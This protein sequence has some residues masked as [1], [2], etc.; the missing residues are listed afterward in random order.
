MCK[1]Y[2]EGFV[3][4]GFT[5]SVILS[6]QMWSITKNK[7][8]AVAVTYQPC[9]VLLCSWT[10]IPLWQKCVIKLTCILHFSLSCYGERNSILLSG[11]SREPTTFG[12][13]DDPWP[14]NWT[15]Q[16]RTI[17]MHFDRPKPAFR[18][19][20]SFNQKRM[21]KCASSKEGAYACEVWGPHGGSMKI[22]LVWVVT[23]CSRHA[24]PVAHGQCVALDTVLCC[25]QRY[26]KWQCVV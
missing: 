6:Y 4:H 14:M 11:S 13:L 26:L 8:T 2:W 9:L 7:H 21:W 1:P 10:Y 18:L 23:L 22:M 3:F 25:P 20:Y 12:V 5:F 16:S 15:Q 19:L 17:L 24:Q